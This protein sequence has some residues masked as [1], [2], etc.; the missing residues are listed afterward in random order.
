MT[1]EDGNPPSDGIY[2]FGGSIAVNA[3]AIKAGALLV[4]ELTDSEPGSRTVLYADAEY[5][6]FWATKG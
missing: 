3:S 4:G 2:N 6:T 5:G 1:D